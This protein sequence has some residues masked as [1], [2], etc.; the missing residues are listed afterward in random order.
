MAHCWS[1]D[2]FVLAARPSSADGGKD[3][4]EKTSLSGSW[5]KKDAEP[6][7]KFTTEGE[8]TIYPHGDSVKIQIECSYT[9]TKEGLVKAKVKSHGGAENVVEQVKNVVPVGME[10]QF[11]WKVE[12]EAATFNDVEAEEADSAKARLERDYAKKD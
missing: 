4:N 6:K 9:F 12:G 1:A 10:S 5:E 8:L 3:D 2:F 11:K 7:A